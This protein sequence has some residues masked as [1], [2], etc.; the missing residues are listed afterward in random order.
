MHAK[1][2]VSEA[3]KVK[4][5]FMF[6]FVTRMKFVR[7]TRYLLSQGAHTGINFINSTT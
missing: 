4:T 6:D 2:S 7:K 3:A 5:Q 1:V